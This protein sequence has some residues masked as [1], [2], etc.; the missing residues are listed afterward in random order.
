V[1][2]NQHDPAARA[3]VQRPVTLGQRAS[4]PLEDAHLPCGATHHGP[5]GATGC[6]W[7]HLEKSRSR[8]TASSVQP[9]RLPAAENRR[10][11]GEDRDA[12]PISTTTIAGRHHL[13]PATGTSGMR[14]SVYDSIRLHRRFTA[15]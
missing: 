8:T 13:F 6:R 15:N 1:G 3:G 11:S 10:P 12:A 9:T 2:E 4:R 14:T 7:S 5:D